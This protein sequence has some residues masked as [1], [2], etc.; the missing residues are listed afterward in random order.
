MA[1]RTDFIKGKTIDQILKM[2]LNELKDLTESELRVVV[3]RGVSAGNKRLRRYQAKKGV[4]PGDEGAKYSD[5]AFSTVGKDRQELL[6]EFKKIKNFMSSK[7]SS[8]GGQQELKREAIQYFNAT[9][10]KTGERI[11]NIDLGNVNYD[12]FWQAYEKLKELKPEIADKNFK[13]EVLEKLYNRVQGKKWFNVDKAVLAIDKEITK[14]YEKNQQIKTGA[15]T[16]GFYEVT[17]KPEP[18]PAKP[19]ATGYYRKNRNK[20][21]GAYK[22]KSNKATGYYK[23]KKKKK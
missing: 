14:I 6:E 15:G 4:L 21:T 17:P 18:K 2:P 22:G 9:D 23:G 19:K 7:T 13:Y 5:V 16:S 10:P 12:R 3:G 11:H 1:K 20:A 8:L